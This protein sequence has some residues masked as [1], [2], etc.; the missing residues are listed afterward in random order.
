MA[1]V[2]FDHVLEAEE[3]AGVRTQRHLLRLGQWLQRELHERQAVAAAAGA[4]TLEQLYKIRVA[5][6]L[7][8]AVRRAV[9]HFHPADSAES[10]SA[11][12]IR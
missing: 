10:A 2:R 7:H 3:A 4:R 6:Y 1:V 11:N 5:S 9:R 12:A 8:L